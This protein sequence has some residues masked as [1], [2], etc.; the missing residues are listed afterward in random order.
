MLLNEKLPSQVYEFSA[1]NCS[2][3]SLAK[4][5]KLHTNPYNFVACLPNPYK[6]SILGDI[7]RATIL[8]F[9]SSKYFYS[10]KR[11]SNLVDLSFEYLRFS[12]K[13]KTTILFPSPLTFLQLPMGKSQKKWST[14]SLRVA[15]YCLQSG[16]ISSKKEEWHTS[17]LPS[18]LLN[19][20]LNVKGDRGVSIQFC[21][22]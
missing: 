18:P 17:P 4:A 21:S 22:R 7:W 13:W 8:P 14:L 19:P 2:N 12:N 10:W 3:G 6:L 16:K 1:E 15:G 20:V 9:S 11:L 5:P